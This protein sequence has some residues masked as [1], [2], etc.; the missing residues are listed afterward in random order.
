MTSGF[1]VRPRRPPVVTVLVGVVVVVVAATFAHMFR[2]IIGWALESIGSSTRPTATARRL[3]RLQVFV[4]ASA[5]VGVAATIGARVDRRRSHEVGVEAVAASARGEGRSI[6][7]VATAARAFATW[8]VSSG[9]VS[10]GRESAIIETGGAV[11][12]IAGR[13]TGGKGDAMATVGIAAAFAA[14]YHAP[15]ASIMYVE[16]HLRVRESRRALTFAI[17][18]A[19]GGHVVGAYLLGG[20]VIFPPIQ[21]SYRGV[22]WYGILGVLPA[23]VAARLFLEVRVRLRT[24]PVAARLGLPR[25]VVI[26]GLSIL[27]GGAVAVFPLAAGN[28]MDALREFSARSTVAIALALSVGK[29]VGTLAALGAGAPGGVLTPTISV[30]A[31]FALLALLGMH[32]LGLALDHPWDAA[33]AA[34]AVGLTV[35]LRSPIV[36]IVLVPELLGDYRLVPAIAVVV[37]VAWLLDRGL[38]RIAVGLGERLPRGVH[39]EDA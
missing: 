38:D 14:A 15:L 35:G 16:E 24:A 25:W 19:V 18:G 3:G 30:A 6:S 34:M 7:A 36:A 12:A 39:D 4:V 29:L 13:R 1:D 27:A 5:A 2:E 20:R 22:L 11:G 23:L 31:G 21:G 28:G 33:V 8:L 10:I 37:A 26:A 9:V 17:A 32:G